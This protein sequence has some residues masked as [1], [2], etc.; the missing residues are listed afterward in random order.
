VDAF[1]YLSVLLS[2]IIGLAMTQILLGY[3]GLL[4]ARARVTFY[5][6]SIIW[7]GLLLILAAQNWWASFGYTRHRGEWTFL[8]FSTV[9]LQTVLLYM[10]AGL[11][12]PDMPPG[13]PV[14]LKAHY[15]RERRV[16]FGL[17]LAMLAVSVSKDWVVNGALPSTPNLAFHGVFA[18][19]SIASALVKRPRFHEII[20]PLVALI[21]AGY[22]TLLFERLT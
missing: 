22:I 1:S 4:L 7:S 14:D 12:L 17:F 8:A 13:Q 16:F 3:R 9:L 15:Y 20:T 19:L 6:P 18:T 11:V 21:T 5:V 10:I 2:I